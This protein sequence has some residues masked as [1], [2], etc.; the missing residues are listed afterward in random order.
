LHYFAITLP[1]L[2][3]SAARHLID[4]TSRLSFAKQLGRYSLQILEMDKI[5]SISLPLNHEVEGK[6]GKGTPKG[7]DWSLLQL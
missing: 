3:F 5:F 1:E 2:F 7:S 6:M 4:V